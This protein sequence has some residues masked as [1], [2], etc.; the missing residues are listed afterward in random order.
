MTRVPLDEVTR[1]T[2]KPCEIVARLIVYG[3][4]SSERRRVLRV[5][6]AKELGSFSISIF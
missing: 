3:L 1:L 2:A 5:H 6:V 4:T